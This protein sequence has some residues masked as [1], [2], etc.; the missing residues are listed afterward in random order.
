[1]SAPQQRR[2]VSPAVFRRRRLVLGVGLLAVVI[3]VVLIIVRPGSAAPA[4]T[5]TPTLTAVASKA[6]TAAPSATPTPTAT[7]I[8]VSKLPACD[9]SS[10]EVKAFV[11]GTTAQNYGASAKP[12]LTL[13]VT[14]NGGSE[15][16][17]NVGTNSQVFTITSGSETY[18][19]SS[20][21]QSGAT[22]TLAIFKP[23]QTLTSNPITWNR[24][25]STSRAGGTCDAK[26]PAAPAKGAS[27]FL[28]TTV[29]GVDSSNRAQ[30]ILQ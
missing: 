30:I 12:A 20:D 8:D 24:V 1:M 15:C 21:C 2:P 18:W 16:Y 26:S 10:M 28:S 14:N 29:G 7:T 25:L 4:P 22:E 3:A 27:Y 9:A 17:F 11:D 5:P 6:A 13:S 19:K 23:G